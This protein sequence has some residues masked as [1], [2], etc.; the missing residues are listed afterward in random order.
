MSFFFSFLLPFMANKD[1]YVDRLHWLITITVSVRVRV[2]IRVSLVWVISVTVSVRVSAKVRVSLVWVIS[3]T[4]S[5]RVSVKIRVSLVSVISVSCP[6]SVTC[7]WS[8]CKGR[9]PKARGS[10]RR[11]HRV[12]ERRILQYGGAQGAQCTSAAGVSKYAPKAPSGRARQARVCRRLVDEQARVSRRLKQRVVST[13]S[14]EP[15]R[16]PLP[17]NNVTFSV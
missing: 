11:R 9:A 4:V 1:E 16:L 7:G 12:A 10:R 2:K 17:R 6:V 3:V 15:W 14:P 13:A 8:I 5:V